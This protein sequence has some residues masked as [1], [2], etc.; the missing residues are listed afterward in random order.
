MSPNDTSS[1][2]IAKELSWLSFNERVIQE[3][4]N[5]ATP[6]IERI[7]FLGIFSNNLDEFFRVR[8]ADVRRI[9]AFSYG[10]KKEQADQLLGD[11]RSRVLELQKRFTVILQE[12]IEMLEQHDIDLVN[13]TEL[14]ESQGAFV[15]Q[16]FRSNVWDNLNP[17]LLDD[18][19]P[20]PEFRDYAIYFA[21]KIHQKDSYS[22][23]VTEVPN[24]NTPRFVIIPSAEGSK[25][26]IIIVDNIIRY[27][28][29]QLF[30]GILDFTRVEAYIFKVTRDA[31]L[32]L[33]EG[34]TQSMIDKVSNSLKRRQKADPV[35]MVYDES[36]P[37]DLLDFLVRKL[38]LTNYDS[39]MA[40]GRYHNSKD[41]ITFPNVGPKSLEF[42]ATKTLQSQYFRQAK[43]A[44]DAI[45]AQDI[46]LYYPYHTFDHII[47][48][49]RMAAIDPK[50]KFINMSLYRV[51]AD[52]KI[53]NS[54]INAATNQ[55]KVTVVVELTAR[56]DE[57]ANIEWARRLQDADVNVI[58]GIDG[59]KVHS[60][61]LLVGRLENSRLRYYTHIGTGNFNEKT[62]KYYTDLS[63][64]TYDQD[65]GKEVEQ[66]FDYIRHPYKQYSYQKLLVSPVSFRKRF[67]ELI[68]QEIDNAIAGKCAEIAIKCNNLF[69]KDIVALLEAASQQGVKVKGIVR[70]MCTLCP[71]TNEIHNEE[72][73]VEIDKQLEIISI[74]D[75]YLEHARI[76]I[77][78]ND[79]DPVYYMGSADLM[80]RNI[81]HRVE[82]VTPI[83]NEANKAMVQKIFDLQWQDNVSARIIDST[84]SN[85]Y[86]QADGK[87]KVRSQDAI[88]R[89]LTTLE[90]ETTATDDREV[91]GFAH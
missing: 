60:K 82:V 33:G 50:V 70:G 45:A 38:K 41:F 1:N 73:N 39:I 88:R 64:F 37:Q 67:G 7:R 51:A 47:E 83:S 71:N 29:P 62:A 75:R 13:E 68:Q 36:M 40:G 44:F 57:Q 43:T 28:L 4:E 66:V 17:V 6:L 87:K 11:I 52:S 76:Y 49:I 24:S 80:T 59:L 32:E 15:E 72:D 46:L 31:E 8:V 78:H 79:G 9:A 53:I 89:Y 55:K 86:R 35:R 48:F 20:L 54:L 27:C 26:S 84:Q 2:P 42:K 30:E 21:I 5:P 85:Q 18:K 25:K 23:A 69:D 58:F 16:Y 77:F 22:Y 10:Q 65:I 81:D 74:V 14:N 34:I 19:L 61:L 12:I 56:F 3:A 91:N 90:R 63:L